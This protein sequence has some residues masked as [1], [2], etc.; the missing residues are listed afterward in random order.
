VEEVDAGDIWGQRRVAITP[1]EY[2]DSV[3]NRLEG[4]A[5][6]LIGEALPGMLAGAVRPWPQDHERATFC[7]PR[8]PE[9]GRID[10]QWPAERIAR[11]VRAQSRPYPG[12]YTHAGGDKVTI[13]RAAVGASRAGEPGETVTNGVICGDGMLLEIQEAQCGTMVCT[14]DDVVNSRTGFLGEGRRDV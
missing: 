14:L 13:W 3:L 9:D 8:R 12:A 6:G 2:V 7:A 5:A 4:E 10:W 1:D 11:F